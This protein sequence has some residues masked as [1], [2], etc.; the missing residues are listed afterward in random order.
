M[1]SPPAMPTARHPQSLASCPTI[2]PVA[3]AAPETTT[4]WPRSGFPTS[5]RPKYAVSVVVPRA[6]SGRVGPTPS[7]ILVT[8]IGPRPPPSETA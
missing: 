1:R 2:E 3:P 7:G 5:L 4:V 6:L 8:L